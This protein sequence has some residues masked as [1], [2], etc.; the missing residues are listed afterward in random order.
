MSG[1]KHK[2]P[3]IFELPLRWECECGYMTSRPEKE[4]KP[5]YFVCANCNRTITFTAEDVTRR[6]SDQV[7]TI[8]E[9]HISL[10]KKLGTKEGH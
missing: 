3:S 6:Y 4:F 9:Q 10:S 2:P 8:N 7:K 1:K 5:P